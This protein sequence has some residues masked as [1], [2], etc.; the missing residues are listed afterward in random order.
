MAH[1]AYFLAGDAEEG[2]ERS[3][4]W[5][6]KE[7]GL[8]ASGN[9]DVIVFRYD[10]FSVEDARAVSESAHR[11]S[12]LGKGKAIVMSARRFFHEAQNALLKTF[13]EPPEGTYLF[14]IVP[15]EGVISPT[16]RSR[17]L[18]LP[19]SETESMHELAEA[20]ASANTAG[21]EKIVEKL[22][23]RAKSDKPEE[24]QAARIDA[25]ALAQGLAK[26]SYERRKGSDDA[27]LLAFL[28]DLSR[29]IPILHERSAPL[30][31]IL[32][33]LLIVAPKNLTK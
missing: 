17:L 21:R 3:L 6:E 5:I 26:L 11:T 25:L 12:A 33:H 1:H 15:S 16:L 32:E 9:P 13:E 28:D 8:G 10:L 22:L 30:K 7:L 18:P 24:K 29:F 20:F 23:A 27:D 2:I 31:P 19:G 4:A 14:L